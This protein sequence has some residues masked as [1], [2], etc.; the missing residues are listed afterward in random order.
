V[1]AKTKY[2]C[3]SCENGHHKPGSHHPLAQVRGDADLLVLPQCHN[4]D[5]S[6]NRHDSQS[7]NKHGNLHK[8]D[9]GTAVHTKRVGAGANQKDNKAG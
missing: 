5:I 7:H 9:H 8:A 3:H 4:A 1:T 2:I 6:T